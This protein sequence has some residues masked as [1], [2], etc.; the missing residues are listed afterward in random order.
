M[1]VKV[2]HQFEYHQQRERVPRQSESQT[3]VP[4]LKALHKTKHC[5]I[6][7]QIS[8]QALVVQIQ[9][10]YR[11]QM[12]PKQLTNQDK[13]N[14]CATFQPKCKNLLI[15]KKMTKNIHFMAVFYV[16]SGLGEKQRTRPKSFALQEFFA[17][18]DTHNTFVALQLV[19]I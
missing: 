17:S 5:G 2:L 4:A 8:I 3:R 12:K 19:E 15:T 16:F 18:F 7:D 13:L 9:G 11:C 6:F 10:Q 1:L 14:W